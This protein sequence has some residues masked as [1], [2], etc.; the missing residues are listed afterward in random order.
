MKWRRKGSGGGSGGAAPGSSSGPDRAPAIPGLPLPS[1]GNGTG[2]AA[3]TPGHRAGPPGTPGWAPRDTGLGS[4]GRAGGG[5]APG[6]PL[7]GCSKEGNGWDGVQ[8]SPRLGI[9]RKSR[10]PKPS[11]TVLSRAEAWSRRGWGGLS[12]TPSLR[13]CQTSLSQLQKET[14]SLLAFLEVPGAALRFVAKPHRR[15]AGWTFSRFWFFFC[16]AGE[17]EV[18]AAAEIVVARIAAT[19]GGKLSP[20]RRVR[21]RDSSLLGWQLGS[22]EGS[23]GLA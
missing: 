10:A 11:G 18:W 22:R 14:G 9:R 1:A 17:G 13:G 21:V 16:S 6:C 23:C 8:G 4:P 5:G 12:L 20:P 7:R 19:V 15:P 2:R 3:G